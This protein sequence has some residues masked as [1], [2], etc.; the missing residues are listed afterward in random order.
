[1]GQEKSAEIYI[2][3]FIE[4]LLKARCLNSG[5]PGFK[6]LNPLNFSST[7]MK[8]TGVNKGK[9]VL[10]RFRSDFFPLPF[11]NVSNRENHH[12]LFQGVK[13]AAV[14]AWKAHQ[15]LGPCFLVFLAY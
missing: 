3:L 6:L 11:V 8:R 7:H 4:Y 2:A 9:L 1:M 15:C 10:E 14:T 12:L 13:C 5:I